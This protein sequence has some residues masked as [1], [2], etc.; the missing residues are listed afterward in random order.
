MSSAAAAGTATPP[1]DDGGGTQ[2]DWQVEITTY[3]ADTPARARQI[4][5]QALAEADVPVVVGADGYE[6]A[7]RLPRELLEAAP[8][9]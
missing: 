1:L 6:L 2:P 3:R 9:R 7:R 4:I 5:A 8:R